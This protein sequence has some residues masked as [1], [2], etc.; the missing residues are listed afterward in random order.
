VHGGVL[1]SP[2][3]LKRATEA[4]ILYWGQW[5]AER[6]LRPTPRWLALQAEKANAEAE[7]P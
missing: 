5:R 3:G 2:E 6:G 4:V 1:R 7:Q